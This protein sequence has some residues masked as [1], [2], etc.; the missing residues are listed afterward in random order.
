MESRRKIISVFVFFLG[1]LGMLT[2]SGKVASAAPYYQANNQTQ[3]SLSN[4][5]AVEPSYDFQFYF[6]FVDKKNVEP[7]KKWLI[8]N[9]F[10]ALIKH[11]NYDSKWLLLASKHMKFSEISRWEGGKDLEDI[12]DDLAKANGGEYDG[13]DVSPSSATR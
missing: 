11:S 6:Y 13:H 2:Y 8:S 12:F 4:S 10:K 1:I 7:V 5:D 9:K 3:S